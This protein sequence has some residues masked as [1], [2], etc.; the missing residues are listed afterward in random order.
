M[1]T[2]GCETGAEGL[3][4]GWSPKDSRGCLCELKQSRV[5]PRRMGCQA[6][7]PEEPQRTAESLGE[8]PKPQ[9][10]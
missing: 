2:T 5:P 3:T 7:C 9:V 1:E 6:D 10:R 8:Q 4:G